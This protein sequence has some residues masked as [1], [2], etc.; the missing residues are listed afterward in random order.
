MNPQPKTSRRSR[1][2]GFSMV[3][4]MCAISIVGVLLSSVLPSMRDLRTRQALPAVAAEVETDVHLARTL[5]LSSNT[6]VRLSVQA[7]PGSSGS[8]TVVYTGAANAC[9]CGGGGQSVCT[10]NTRLWRLTEQPLA[11]GAS[12]VNVVRTLLFDPSKGTVTLTATLAITDRDDRSVRKIV[13]IMG[14]VRSCTPDGVR[15][16]AACV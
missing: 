6:G 4:P 5:A 13:N 9:S 8:C 7:V 14:R 16:F 1:H 2:T 3:E 11:D 12:L 15:G 10:G